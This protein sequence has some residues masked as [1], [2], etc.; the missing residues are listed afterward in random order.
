MSTFTYEQSFASHPRAVYWS[1]KNGIITPRDVSRRCAKKFIFNCN[2]CN[3]EFIKSLDSIG[4]GSWCPYCCVPSKKLCDNEHCK[5]CYKRSFASNIKHYLLTDKKVN[6]RLLFKFSQKIYNFTCIIC[7]H[8]FPCSL[9]NISYGKWCPYCCVPS[10]KLCDNEHCKSCYKRSFASHSKSALWSEKNDLKPRQVAKNSNVSFLF[11]CDGCKHDF[12]I[13]L[14]AVNS[15]NWCSYCCKPQQKICDDIKCTFCFESS[16]ASHPK[17]KYWHPTKNGEV[18]PRDIMKH[19]SAKYFLFCDIC[20]HDF[21][22]PICNIDKEKTHC[23]YCVAPTKVLCDDANCTFCF[24]RS[25][26]SHPKS[27]YWSEKNKK[28]PRQSIKGSNAIHIFNCIL[29]NSE[30]CSAL[31]NILQGKWCNCVRYKTEQKL[32]DTIRI[33]YL[34]IKKPFIQNWCKNPETGRHLP[35]DFCIPEYKIIIELDGPQHFIQVSDWKNPEEQLVRDTY[36]QK[37]ANENGYSVIRIIQADVFDDSYNWQQE[38]C[39]TIENTHKSDTIENVYLYKNNEYALY[40][41]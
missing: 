3:H 13:P 14:N 33:H 21:E 5:S 2:E 25:F 30:Y 31:S 6:A 32:F 23:I 17:A 26:A 20:K 29:C 11:D 10:K 27:E 15:G 12:P 28:T 1:V 9:A 16:F 37:C 38:L 22:R 19:T 18:K 40:I 7:N 4:A 39:E 36:K 41:N 8:N 35:F 24:N 34:T